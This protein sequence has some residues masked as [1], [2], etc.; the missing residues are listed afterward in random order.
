MK[1]ILFSLLFFLE[2]SAVAAGGLNFY[3]RIKTYAPLQWGVAYVPF[4]PAGKVLGLICILLLLVSLPVIRRIKKEL[5]P[6]ICRRGTL[7]P[8]LF[9]LPFLP[10]NF[11]TILYFLGCTGFSCD[12]NFQ[13]CKDLSCGTI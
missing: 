3:F 6:Q 7:L 9:L 5:L 8:A 11:V 10:V 1:K 12:I 13:I 4:P 2:L